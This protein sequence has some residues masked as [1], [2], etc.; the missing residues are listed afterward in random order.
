MREAIN[1]DVAL[2]VVLEHTPRL[3]PARIASADALG[4]VLA[5]DVCADVAYPP[6]ARAMMDGFAVCAVDAGRSVHVVGEV[7]AGQSSSVRVDEGSA[8]EIMTGAAC[9]AGAGAVVRKEDTAFHGGRVALPEQI[10]AGQHIAPAGSE[11][12]A[13]QAVARAGGEVTPLVVAA[14]ATFG[15][16]EVPVLPPPRCAII[17]TGTEIA[18]PG[19]E[20][21]AVQIRGSNGPM[22]AALAKR[23]G[24]RDISLHHAEDTH[25]ALAVALGLCGAADMVILAGGVCAGKYDLVPAALER[26]GVEIL[27][28]R[29]KQSPGKAMLFGVEGGQTFF[30]LS[31]NPVAC[32]LG[33][34]RYVRAAAGR[35]MGRS[36][37]QPP[38][39][40][41]LAAPLR[42]RA[43]GTRF[44]LCHAA[45][46]GDCWRVTPLRGKGPAD[47]F[48]V[49]AANAYVRV[50]PG[51]GGQEAGARVAFTWA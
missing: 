24:L 29:V 23:A 35:A 34:C 36:E 41:L 19:R 30:G 46:D 11:C 45:A 16:T 42:G 20:P 38:E 14:L 22:L 21:G 28:S 33:F 51:S 47:F 17:T 9:P 5:Q 3:S 37:E 31:G 12:A 43:A 2:S 40:G 10:E 15:H 32:H 7:A 4:L 26:H 44:E 6:F 8:V 39:W 48:T 27:F 18:G 50:D 25:G 13:G 1:P 49:C